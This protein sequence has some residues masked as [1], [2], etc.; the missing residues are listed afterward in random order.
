M[1]L[2]ER[3]KA[4]AVFVAKNADAFLA[5]AVALAVIISLAVGHPSAEVIDAAILGLL[6][7]TALALLRGR[8]GNHDLDDLRQLAADAVSDRPY[9]VVWQ[10]NFW[11][12]SHRDRATVTCTEQIRLTRDEVSENFLWSNGPGRVISA[13]AKWRRGRNDPWIPVPK[14]NEFA[15]RGGLKEIFSFNDEHRR[16]ETLDWCV[17]RVIE[18]QFPDANEGVEIEAATRSEHPRALRIRWP[19]DSPPARI[20]ISEANRPVRAIRAT[21]RGG[22]SYIEE[23]IWGLRVGESVRIDWSW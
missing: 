6:G 3:L 22:R 12:L 10:D 8:R 19:A 15:V 9:E 23:K 13:N 2:W 11:D 18:G 5:M 21:E 17:E 20:E 7:T 16:G 4:A 14:I 1:S